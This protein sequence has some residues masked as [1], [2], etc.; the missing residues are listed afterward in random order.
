VAASPTP[1][2]AGVGLCYQKELHEFVVRQAD[3]LDYLEIVPDTAWTDHG[4]TFGIRRYV[5]DE[6]AL[7]FFREFS[8][9]RPVVAHSIGLSIGSAH[10]FRSEHVAQLARWDSQLDFAWHSDHLAF[11]FV[12]AADDSEYLLGVP[13]SVPRD[14]EFLEILV[15]RILSVRQQIAKP[16]LLENNVSYIDY[17][18]QDHREAAF[19]NELCRRSGCGILLDIHNLYVDK[20]NSALDC[21]VFLDELDFSN[22]VELH[23]AGGLEYGGTYLDAHSGAVNDDVWLLADQIV[24]LCKHLRGVTFELL[25]SWYARLGSNALTEI[26]AR[27]HELVTARGI[28]LG[29]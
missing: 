27:M 13:F 4:E 10:R 11:N 2:P 25:G 12:R 5:D 21:D 22:V 7:G 15:P 26:I 19:L 6:T 23:I 16:F 8:R 3:Q 9:T 1:A 20:R 18:K 17:G 24:P 28:R 29:V 14:N